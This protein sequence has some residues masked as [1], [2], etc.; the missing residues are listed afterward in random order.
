LSA[1]RS[2]G[3]ERELRLLAAVLFGCA[4]A[5]VVGWFGPW[6]LTVLLAWIGFVAA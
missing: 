1:Q 3:A 2:A 6:Q 4:A 5:F